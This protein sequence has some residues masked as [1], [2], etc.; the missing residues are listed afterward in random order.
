MNSGKKL[1][2]LLIAAN[3]AATAFSTWHYYRW[4]L[5]YTASKNFFLLPFV[6]DCPLATFFVMASLLLIYHFKKNINWFYFLA[7]SFALKSA[8]WTISTKALFSPFSFLEA[9]SLII[10][11]AHLGLLAES[12]LLA[13]RLKARRAMFFIPLLWL[14]SN[15]FFDYFLGTHPPVYAENIAAVLALSLVLS[16]FSFG[17]SLV[18]G[19]TA[20]KAGK[21]IEDFFMGVFGE[22]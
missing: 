8:L 11:A 10:I 17:F 1:F 18:W 20:E 2:W 3:I 9:N 22:K 5:A 16:A 7:F 6:P 13:G 15:D 14:L 21:Q 12:F 19:H 4:Q